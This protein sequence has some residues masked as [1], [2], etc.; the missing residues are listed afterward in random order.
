MNIGHDW[1]ATTAMHHFNRIIDLVKT[2]PDAAEL[3]RHTFKIVEEF[4]VEVH[5]HEDKLEKATANR[6]RKV[7]KS[8]GFP[9]DP[10]YI[11][12]CSYGVRTRIFDALDAEFGI[13]I[14]IRHERQSPMWMLVQTIDRLLLEKENAR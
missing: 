4:A 1:M 13:T 8:C 6:I 2:G 3:G 12:Q 14:P 5:T 10:G 7:L 11:A 9:E